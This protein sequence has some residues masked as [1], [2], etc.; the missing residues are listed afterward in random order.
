[1]VEEAKDEATI[2]TP[3]ALQGYGSPTSCPTIATAT[4]MNGRDPCVMRSAGSTLVK[5]A[6]RTAED[7]AI[8]GGLDGSVCLSRV[9][10]HAEAT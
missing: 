5:Q 2:G 9:G 10:L 4:C 6:Q 7:L 8:Y 1:M 3:I